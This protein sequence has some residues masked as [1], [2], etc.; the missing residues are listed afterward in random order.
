MPPKSKNRTEWGEC[1][2]CNKTVSFRDFDKHQVTC[3]GDGKREHGWFENGILFAE[4]F[5]DSGNTGEN[6]KLPLSTRKSLVFMSPSTMKLAG[7]SIGQPVVLNGGHVYTVWPCDTTPP[8]KIALAVEIQEKIGAPTIVT[9][10]SL[11]TPCE[12]ANQLIVS[13]SCSEASAVEFQ[14]Y[15]I[16]SLVGAYVTIGSSL[17]IKYYGQNVSLVVQ[18]IMGPASSEH[19]NNEAESQQL[20]DLSISSEQYLSGTIS[21]YRDLSVSS[22]QTKS[23]LSSLDCNSGDVSLL[24]KSVENIDL[25]DSESVNNLTSTPSKCNND[26]QSQRSDD[27]DL[28]VSTPKSSENMKSQF[29]TPNI[30]RTTST[31]QKCNKFYKITSK[32]KLMLDGKEDGDADEDEVNADTGSVTLE[33]I[34]GLDAEIEMIRE[35]IQLP[36]KHPHVFKSLGLS[37]PRGALLYGAPGSG[38]SSV[39]Q[40]LCNDLN[41]HSVIINA[42]YIWSKNPVESQSK[43]ETAFTEAIS[44]APSIVCIDDVDAIC[45]RKS[46]QNETDRRIVTCLV[47]LIEGLNKGK[48]AEV[49]VLGT[50]SKVEQVDPALRRPGKFDREI[51]IPVPNAIH[52]NQI[53]SK[54][55]RGVKHNVGTEECKMIA[56]CTHGYVGSDLKSLC[57]E[58]GLLALK[59]HLGEVDVGGNYEGDVML[60][61]SDLKQAM[62][63]VQPSAMR[64]VAVHVPKVLWSDIGGQASLKQKL[65]QA[66]EWPLTHP[67]AFTRLGIQPPR[68]VLMY[69]PPGCSKT[70]IAK[71]LATESGLNFLSIKGPE[72]FSKWV[73]ESERAVRELFRKARAAAPSIIFFDEIDALTSE[74]GS[75]GGSNVSERVLAQLLTE[76]DGVESLKDVTIVAATNRPDMIDKALIRPGRI[77]RMV[78]VPLPNAETRN[79]IFQIR[80]RTM[81]LS[82]DVT[83]DH[84]VAGTEGYSGAEIVAVCHE[85]AMAAMEESMKADS[86]TKQHFQTALSL[87]KPRNTP[88][89]M[90][91]FTNFHKNSGL[92]SVK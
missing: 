48:G 66:V 61:V 2:T 85:A 68:G 62:K 53:L 44:K 18:A 84:L 10:E 23:D 70:M 22:E 9:V 80:L 29:C 58:A 42:A 11:P 56:D 73:G 38:K 65:R 39:I 15:A 69:G 75:A 6:I 77:D 86:V 43:L 91:V 28:L 46:S 3:K 52:R 55:L 19:T 35:L 92:H 88:D 16:H 17:A 47:S 45:S 20:R 7:F 34:G 32:T 59:R 54:M 87:V 57:Q 4:I 67:E 33:D 1:V 12:D 26:S 40:A 76:I 50:T 41:I 83:I 71:A 81:P 14:K 13:C 21:Q 51:E 89:S 5:A 37:V 72:L 8:A 27:R 31:G 30:K 49:V 60:E 78:Y 36:L 64:E 74:R 79:D 25:N 82:D 63:T 90:E 24:S